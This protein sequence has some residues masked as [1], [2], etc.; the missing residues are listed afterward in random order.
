MET[1]NTEYEKYLKARKQVE[2]I[3]GFYGHLT[4]YIIFNV[5]IIFINLKYSPEVLW[6]YWTTFSWGIGL[7]F[8]GLK[9]YNLTPFLN[10]DWEERKIK[11][12]MDEENTKN[13]KF[14]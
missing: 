1:N 13:N 11:Q 9:V 7:F 8:H 2:A 12:F 14:E 6:F 4:F 5:I 10:K 3:K